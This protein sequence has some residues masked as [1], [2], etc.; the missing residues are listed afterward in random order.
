MV[1]VASDDELNVRS[2][3]GVDFPTQFRLAPLSTE[4]VATGHNRVIS[5]SG[6]WSEVRVGDRIGWASS[7]YLMQ[8]GEVDDITAR[9]Y[10]DPSDR[11]T[12]PTL[13]ELGISA[14]PTSN[15][16]TGDLTVVIVDG[17]T[18][19]DLGEVTV[20]VLGFADDAVGGER[21]RVFAERSPNGGYTLRTV[22]RTVLCRRA[23]DGNGLCV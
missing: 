11:P 8:P 18:R 10:P 22:E 14:A 23:V 1:G 20:D 2:G 17:P 15:A 21:L 3:P 6:S 5:G 9:L 19:G 13:A 4:A 16:D 12:A 7:A